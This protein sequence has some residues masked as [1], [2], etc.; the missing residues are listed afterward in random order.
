MPSFDL[1]AMMRAATR[2]WNEA[3]GMVYIEPLAWEDVLRAVRDYAATFDVAD[4]TWYEQTVA[5]A[6]RMVNEWYEHGALERAPLSAVS[7]R[8]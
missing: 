8:H 6:A 2:E 7:R 3:Q 5:L 1:E 4:Q